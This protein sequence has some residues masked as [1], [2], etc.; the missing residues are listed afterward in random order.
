MLDAYNTIIILKNRTYYNK[1]KT[2]KVV[3]GFI[4]RLIGGP[5]A[6]E[7]RLLAESQEKVSSLKQKYQD[8]TRAIQENSGSW[9]GRFHLSSLGITP[10]KYN[11][12]AKEAQ[13][14]AE[15][16]ARLERQIGRSSTWRAFFNAIA[17]GTLSFG[18]YRIC[19]ETNF[20]PATLALVQQIYT[21]VMNNMVKPAAEKAL[22]AMNKM[23]DR[24]CESRIPAPPQ[25]STTT[26]PNENANSINE[27]T[28][29]SGG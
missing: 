23:M 21:G 26:P 18:G 9:M 11:Q 7:K 20:I 15:K 24:A 28:S 16:V 13:E 10:E 8:M 27:T 29:S 4:I 2:K 17:L 1:K 6:V 19:T 14:T 25:A 22:D 5:S 12:V 3:M